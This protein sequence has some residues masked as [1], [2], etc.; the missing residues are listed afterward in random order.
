M[1]IKDRQI[2]TA[3]DPRSENAK[4]SNAEDICVAYK[5]L[6]DSA[7][8]LAV[9]CLLMVGSNNNNNNTMTPPLQK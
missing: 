2:Q 1:L 6:S 9:F 7:S 3:S 8:I 5:S 4:G